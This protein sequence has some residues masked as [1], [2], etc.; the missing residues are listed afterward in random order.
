M[1]KKVTTA[2]TYPHWAF[3]QMLEFMNETAAEIGEYLYVARRID[4]RDDESWID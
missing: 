1:A 2:G 3:R 4:E